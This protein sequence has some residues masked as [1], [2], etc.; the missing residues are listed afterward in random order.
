MCLHSIPLRP[1]VVL[2]RSFGEVENLRTSRQFRERGVRFQEP[3]KPF[4]PTGVCTVDHVSVPEVRTVELELLGTEL[5]FKNLGECGKGGIAV[6]RSEPTSMNEEPPQ[7]WRRASQ[8]A[9]VVILDKL[10]GGWSDIE[11]PVGD[12]AGRSSGN[13]VQTPK[14]IN[15]LV[16]QNQAAAVS[17]DGDLA[18]LLVHKPFDALD[19]ADF[20]LDAMRDMAHVGPDLFHA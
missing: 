18:V 6:T 19:S 7:S 2:P 13:R 15:L 1:L 12:E 11:R 10:S 8:P 20:S 17:R 4:L 3:T 14:A 9:D 5:R 16:G